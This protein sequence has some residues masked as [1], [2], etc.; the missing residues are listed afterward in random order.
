M[1][2]YMANRYMKKCSTSLITKEMQIKNHNGIT[3]HTCYSSYYQND[4]RSM[5]AWTGRRRNSCVLLVLQPLWETVWQFLKK[6]KIE[7]P[8]D[9]AIPLLS[10]YTQE[11]KSRSQRDI[12]TPCSLQH[13]SQKP[14]HGYILI[15]HW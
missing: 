3:P 14:R 1:V 4:K 13:Y 12:C 8:Y 5:L 15:V 11:K 2:I 9:S 6:L 7:L 10:L